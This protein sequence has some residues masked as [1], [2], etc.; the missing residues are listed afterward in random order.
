MGDSS[1][2]KRKKKVN[3]ML[4]LK[5]DV[6]DRIWQHAYFHGLKNNLRKW[7]IYL[8]IYILLYNFHPDLDIDTLSR[9]RSI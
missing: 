8:A 9:S 3:L 1:D 2:R 7:L 5:F 6:Y 4:I